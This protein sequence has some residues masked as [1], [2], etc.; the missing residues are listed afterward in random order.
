MNSSPK[1]AVIYYSATGNVAQLAHNIALGATSV[2]AETRVL[3]VQETAPPEA[4]ASNPSWQSFVEQ[5]TDE[6]ANLSEL[7]WADGIAL[8]SPTRFGGPA[9]QLK[10]FID[11][12]GSLWAKGVLANK[13][14]TS[15]TSASTQH[16]GLESTILAMNN[17]FYHWGTLIMPLG[18]PTEHVR[19]YSGNPY[20]AS[21]FASSRNSDDT[22]HITAAFTQG[23]RLAH[24]A[25][26]CLGLKQA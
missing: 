25:A 3:R 15:F 10:A 1:I 20:G 12:T 13:V 2:G 21:Q 24:V 9:S 5:A 22:S 18:Y 14:G 8:G 11:T 26:A 19:K 23:E 17:I 6:V 4:I 16:G 7:E